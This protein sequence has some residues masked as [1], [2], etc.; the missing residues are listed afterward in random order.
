MNGMFGIPARRLKPLFVT[1][2]SLLSDED[3]QKYI[4][5]LSVDDIINFRDYYD[6]NIL[7]GIAES[8]KP[9]SWFETI[10]N[11][12]G[13]NEFEEMLKYKGRL[14]CC[15]FAVVKNSAAFVALI[16][17]FSIDSD[18]LKQINVYGTRDNIDYLAYLLNNQ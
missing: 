18:I 10:C 17:V 13:Q 8:G 14:S 1:V 12:V 6:A 2:W 4:H 7:Y 5:Y 9:I 3:F 16:N 11:I 15:P